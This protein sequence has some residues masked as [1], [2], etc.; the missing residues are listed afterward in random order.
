LL[1]GTVF[2]AEIAVS[3]PEI[4]TSVLRSNELRT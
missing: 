3:V 4:K 2:A 1:P